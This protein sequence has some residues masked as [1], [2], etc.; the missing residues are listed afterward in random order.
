MMHMNR[1][2]LKPFAIACSVFV[3]FTGCAILVAGREFV[4]FLVIC[5]LVS[6]LFFLLGTS[7]RQYH[8]S[9]RQKQSR[10]ETMRPRRI[11][12]EAAPRYSQRLEQF[13][14]LAPP[15][16]RQSLAPLQSQMPFRSTVDLRHVE[17]VKPKSPAVIRRTLLLIRR[18]LRGSSR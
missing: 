11:R 12:R 8:Q 9:R 18:I 4:A 17:P 6:V 13:L 2:R 3:V 15:N 1:R 5:L 7:H 16:R 14:N 10:R